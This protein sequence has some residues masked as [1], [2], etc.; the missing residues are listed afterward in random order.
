[1]YRSPPGV[2]SLPSQ[3]AGE[4]SPLAFHSAT[5]FAQVA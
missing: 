2:K 1:M 4:L 5:R 3:N